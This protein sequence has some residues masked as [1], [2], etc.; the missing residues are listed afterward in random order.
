MNNRDEDNNSPRQNRRHLEF[1]MPLGHRPLVW[2]FQGQGHREEEE[3]QPSTSG[4]FG[5]R[6]S[7]MEGPV[8]VRLDVVPEFPFTQHSYF[9]AL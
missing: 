6:S 3:G 4:L 1:V 5:A 2:H 8:S 9:R 7:M